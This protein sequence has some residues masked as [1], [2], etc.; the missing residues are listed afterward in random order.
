MLSKYREKT[1]IN[2]IWVIGVVVLFVV[3]SFAYIF[4]AQK[5]LTEG[6]ERQSLEIVNQGEQQLEKKL[7]FNF[8]ILRMLSR[9]IAEEDSTSI[10]LLQ[11]LDDAQ[12]SDYIRLGYIDNNG[13]ARSSD[14]IIF[15]ASNRGY[16][17]QS[18]TG[19]ESISEVIAEGIGNRRG[20]PIIVISVPVIKDA[21][22]NG[23]LF[24]TMRKDTFAQILDIKFYDQLGY[25]LVMNNEGTI[26]FDSGNT[27][28]QGNMYDYIEPND[29]A[30]FKAS[31]A[32]NGM[33]IV[34]LVLNHAGTY[35]GYKNISKMNN[36][37]FVT[38]MPDDAVFAKMKRIEYSTIS[39]FVILMIIFFGISFYIIYC[40][41]QQDKLLYQYAYIDPVTG[42]GNRNA[43]LTSAVNLM[44][45][46]NSTN[47][48][49]SNLIVSLD[50][51]N[52][53][54]VNNVVGFGVGNII[55]KILGESLQKYWGDSNVYA[56]LSNDNFVMLLKGY[57]AN[58]VFVDKLSCFQA[59][60]IN[61]L[62]MLD[63]KVKINLSYGVY[64]LTASDYNVNEALD[65]AT[66]ARA[67]AKSSKTNKVV[68]YNDSFWDKF[69]EEYFI[70][71]NINIAL[72]QQQFLVYFQPKFSFV[73]KKIAGA[74]A[75]IRWNH[76]IE[77]MIPP[78]KF[79]PVAE[80][81]GS[82]V[83]ID[84][85]VLKEVCKFLQD[86]LKNKLPVHP[87]AINCSMVEF[88]QTDFVEYIQSIVASYQVPFELIEIEITETTIISELSV[89]QNIIKQLRSLGIKITM[90]DF[91]TGYSSLSYLQKIVF[92]CMKL[93]KSFLNEFEHD[94]QG[95]NIIKAIIDLAK[96]LQLTV[97]AEGI[98][99]SKQAEFLDSLD[100]DY[101]QGYYFAR[102]MLLD[103]YKKLLVD[104][105]Q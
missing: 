24:A 53:K 51:D 76:P 77:G 89:A 40:Q 83:S 26:I 17:Q 98:E 85:Y 6:I 97:V 22:I 41:Y 101:A 60:F 14:G 48:K 59:V 4:S 38:V 69:E 84:R 45:G 92:D 1:V 55:L 31:I 79:I 103:D 70:E 2:T 86:S 36:W 19:L 56:R 68:L 80:K 35:I 28:I 74:E 63:I 88:Y 95:R 54:L 12:N 93:D 3:L 20:E 67:K 11:M 82:I 78:N 73:S 21:N 7:E 105:H 39:L 50:I 44:N 34:K 29:L 64:C 15:D 10:N 58:E 32:E 81:T 27:A 16:F 47:S 65:K 94:L 90:D 66:V 37:K 91:G 61:N 72:E 18:I 8:K 13:L 52:F 62:A 5:F 100:C 71:K 99:T 49:I 96:S 23:V 25:T 57:T 33:G 75:L 9:Q 102:P 43:F 104:N 42:M 46:V 87:I 30:Q